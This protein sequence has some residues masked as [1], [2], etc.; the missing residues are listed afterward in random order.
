[1]PKNEIVADL[2]RG[3]AEVGKQCRHNIQ[4]INGLI[5]IR[6]EDRVSK[7]AESRQSPTQRPKHLGV[8][9]TSAIQQ[10]SSGHEARLT[11]V[12]DGPSLT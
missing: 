8:S 3:S 6:L 1:M 12:P 7:G 4:E 2:C 11:D 9:L 10:R 5:E